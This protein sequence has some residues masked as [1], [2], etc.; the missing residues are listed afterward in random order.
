MGLLTNSASFVRFN[1][2]GDP[3]ADFWEFAAERISKYAFRDID[4]NYDERSIGWVSCLDMFDSEFTHASYA[5]ADYLIL[6]LRIDERKVPAAA[7]KKF[8]LKE[9]GR[10][11]KERQIPRLSRDH[12]QEIK[13]NMRLVLLKKAIPI[14][15]VYDMAWNLS[16][17][18][19]LFFSTSQKAIGSLEEFFKESFDLHLMM[20]IPYIA[21]GHL[22]PADKVEALPYINEEILI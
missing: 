19:V 15:A 2:E 22:L 17:N 6:S 12:R 21:A 5:A 3:P 4:D 10:I 7:L 18:T 13:E 1:V 16:N 8:T 11:K 14:P 20:Q 9:E